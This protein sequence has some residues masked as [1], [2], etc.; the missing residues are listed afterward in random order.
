MSK[1]VSMSHYLL[2]ICLVFAIIFLSG[3]TDSGLSL[4]PIIHL[5]DKNL[6][7]KV[8]WKVKLGERVEDQIESN[9]AMDNG[10][11]YATTYDHV[12]AFDAITGEKKWENYL[13][14]YHLS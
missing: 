6:A 8:Q 5:A 1:L 2:M 10:V 7:A 3:G 13:S 4:K 9:L 11:I 12:Y 14:I